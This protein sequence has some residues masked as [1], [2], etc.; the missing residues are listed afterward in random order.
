MDDDVIIWHLPDHDGLDVY[1]VTKGPMVLG[2]FTGR[3][4]GSTVFH[5]AVQHCE[6]GRSVWLKDDRPFRRLNLKR[7]GD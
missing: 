6:P 3:S 5:A 2:D 1:R 4:V 7:S